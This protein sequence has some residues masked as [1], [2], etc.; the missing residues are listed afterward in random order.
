MADAFAPAVL[1]TPRLLLT[2]LRPADADAM[3]DVLGDA[4]L[5]EFTGGRPADLPRLRERYAALAAG[6]PRPGESWLNWIVRRRPG[7]EPVGTVQAT[8]TRRA[9]GGWTA[10]VAWVVGVPWQG[11]GYPGE[12]ARALVGWLRDGGAD[13]VRALIHPDHRASAAVAAAAGLAP[14]ADCVDGER[15]WLA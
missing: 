13:P 10:D 4:R 7:E 11:R 9:A 6:S 14:T 5:H 12:A 2:P 1:T 8:L 15:V 3:V